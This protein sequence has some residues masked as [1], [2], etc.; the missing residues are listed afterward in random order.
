[1]SLNSHDWDNV[2]GLA[3]RLVV[4]VEEVASHLNEVSAF[5]QQ[6]DDSPFGAIA[7]ELEKWNEDDVLVEES[8]R[9]PEQAENGV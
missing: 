7:A 2:F 1:M 5:L 8:S 4:A 3:E 9:A 6:I